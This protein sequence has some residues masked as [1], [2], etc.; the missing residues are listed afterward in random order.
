MDVLVRIKRLVLRGDVRFTEKARLELERDDLAP[1]DALEAI[2][3]A[4]Y[5]HKTLRSTS[6][7]RSLRRERLYV[8]I[9]VSFDGIPVY[10]KGTI[11]REGRRA[12][13]YILISSKRSLP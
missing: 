9:G 4:S 7:R 1:E 5:I 6:T 11:R 8:I 10:T 2:V 3:C 13:L 12:V